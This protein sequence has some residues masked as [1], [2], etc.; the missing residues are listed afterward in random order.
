MRQG[1][2]ATALVPDEELSR[3]G[4]FEITERRVPG[5]EGAPEISLLI[6]RPGRRP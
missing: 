5:P 2:A 3:G 1:A 6:A 4:T